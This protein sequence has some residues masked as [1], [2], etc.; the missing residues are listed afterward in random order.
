[1]SVEQ[2]SKE[3]MEDNSSKEQ[4]SYD[5]SG[6]VKQSDSSQKERE[7]RLRKSY[8][9]MQNWNDDIYDMYKSI[10]SSVDEELFDQICSNIVG[11]AVKSA[12]EFVTGMKK[13]Q[14][15]T[16][17]RDD[18]ERADETIPNIDWPSCRAFDE[19]IGMAKIEK[20]IATW[21]RSSSWMHHVEFMEKDNREY[22]TR[23][24]FRVKWSQPTRRRPVPRVI[25]SVYFTLIASTIKPKSWPVEVYYVF[26]SNRL[27]HRPGKSRFRE[28]W[29]KNIV[30][31]K[32]KVLEHVKF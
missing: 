1:M 14:M 20:F 6:S 21:E 12:S 11:E 9:P 13:H 7:A 23:Y 17:K 10:D 2:Q 30:N 31:N 26:E 4:D 32:L 28:V 15:K 8:N 22:D 24:L 16:L 5:Q 29:L 3:S 19:E 18:P 27:V 25:A